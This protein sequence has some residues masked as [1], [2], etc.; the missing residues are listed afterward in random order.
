MPKHP[1]QRAGGCPSR[2]HLG[3]LLLPRLRPYSTGEHPPYA[4]QTEKRPSRALSSNI[5]EVA[6]NLWQGQLTRSVKS[7]SV[8]KLPPGLPAVRRSCRVSMARYTSPIPPVVTS[9]WVSYG[10]SFVPGRGTPKRL[11]PLTRPIPAASPELKRPDR[12]PRVRVVSRPLYVAFSMVIHT[13]GTALE[14]RF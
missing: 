10:P 3:S 11:A 8:P 7:V 2:G 5:K 6:F 13:E 4:P 9:D 1:G 12:L 14:R